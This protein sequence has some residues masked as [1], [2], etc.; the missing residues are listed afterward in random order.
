VSRASDEPTYGHTDQTHDAA[1]AL[2][3][4]VA[5]KMLGDDA[6]SRWLGIALL[7][8]GIDRAV[9]QMTI[10]DDMVNGFGTS[11]GGILFSLADTAFACATNGHGAVSVAI[12][13]SVS[14]PAAVRPGDVLT[15]TAIQESASRRLGFCAV[16]VQNQHG[17]T[18]GHFRGTVYRTTTPHFPPAS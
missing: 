17:T 18:V 2:A 12:D 15:A 11:H 14:Y 10:R 1:T 6:F 5:E 4:A 3:R 7:E 16:T 13:C 9:V 8:V